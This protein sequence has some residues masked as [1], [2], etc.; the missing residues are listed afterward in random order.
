MCAFSLKH[1][2]LTKLNK[3]MVN[4]SIH[5]YSL[6]LLRLYVSIIL[7]YSIIQE[8]ICYPGGLVQKGAHN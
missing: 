8:I 7:E 2:F 3:N 1:K 4:C 6:T 5:N